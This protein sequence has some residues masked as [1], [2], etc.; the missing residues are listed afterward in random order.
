MTTKTKDLRDGWRKRGI[1]WAMLPAT[2]DDL[3]ALRDEI[4]GLGCTDQVANGIVGWVSARAAGQDTSGTGGPTAARY[5]KILAEVEASRR[6]RRGRA[7][8]NPRSRPVMSGGHRLT[9]EPELVSA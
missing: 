4:K 3:A 2:L 1:E 7:A 9:R 5:R 6:K 8:H